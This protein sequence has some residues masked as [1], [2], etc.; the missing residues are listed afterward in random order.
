MKKAKKTRLHRERDVLRVLQS[1]ELGGVAGGSDTI[2]KPP[3]L[4]SD[5]KV[6]CCV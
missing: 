1:Y 2:I 6:A 5:S 3:P 4:T